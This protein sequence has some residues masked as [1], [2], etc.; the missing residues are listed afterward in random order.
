MWKKTLSES[1]R[2]PSMAKPHYG[3]PKAPTPSAPPIYQSPSG[4]IIPRKRLEH[5]KN[6]VDP[7]LNTPQQNSTM[8]KPLGVFS[9]FFFKKIFGEILISPE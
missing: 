4:S 8:M 3:E 1:T 5:H 6:K 2:S 7:A 9:K